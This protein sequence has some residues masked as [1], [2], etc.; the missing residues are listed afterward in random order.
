MDDERP[1][2][3]KRCLNSLYATDADDDDDGDLAL[4]IDSTFEYDCW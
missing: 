4:L 1:S 3:D 2:P